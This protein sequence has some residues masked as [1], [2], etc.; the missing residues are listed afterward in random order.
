MN[1][2]AKALSAYGQDII[3]LSDGHTSINWRA[4]LGRRLLDLQKR[5]TRTGHGHWTNE[6]D[7][8][9]ESD[10]V[11]VTSYAILALQNSLDS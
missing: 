7:R 6:S 3:P 8:F 1:V 4:D 9:W 5:D 2:L 11:L 10:P